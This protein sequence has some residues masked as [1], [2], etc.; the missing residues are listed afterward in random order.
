MLGDILLIFF[1]RLVFH[2]YDDLV[3]LEKS[4]EGYEENGGEKEKMG[5]FMDVAEKVV[6]LFDL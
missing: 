1:D 4:M 2:R 6:L 5:S 3:D